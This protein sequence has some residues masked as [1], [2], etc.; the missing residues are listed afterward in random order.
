MNYFYHILLFFITLIAFIGCS[1]TSLKPSDAAKCSWKDISFN[2]VNNFCAAPRSAIVQHE[3][4]IL[5][6][7]NGDIVSWNIDTGKIVENF[8]STSQYVTRA[9]KAVDNKIISGTSDM[10][11]YLYSSDGALLQK[12]NYSKGSIFDIASYEK[13][14]YVAFGNSELGVVDQE[15]LALLGLYTR[16]KYLIYSLLFDEEELKLYSGSDD[17]TI[18]V[19]SVVNDGTLKFSHTVTGFKSAVKHILKASDN[20][21]ITTGRGDVFMYDKLLKKELSVIKVSDANIISSLIYKNK[22][23]VGDA[24]GFFY[25]YDIKKNT[26]IF[27]KK[28]KVDGL[29]RTISPYNDC[30]IITTK[31]KQVNKICDLD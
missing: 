16:H 3:N 11:L 24:K 12:K 26:L 18:G 7:D 23:Y 22:L 1:N 20:I 6:F 4:I 31:T 27:H 10:K 21:I 29:V 13:K 8:D 30:F 15:T 28:T 19:W 17:E 5:S 14:L 25:I 2:E 9:L